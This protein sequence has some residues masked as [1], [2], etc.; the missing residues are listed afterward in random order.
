MSFD[1]FPPFISSQLQYLLAHYPQLIKVEQVWSGS[2]YF[3]GSLDR[4]TLLIPYCLDYLKWDIIYN[5][6]FPLAA[7]DVIFGPEDEDFHPFHVLGGE[8]KDLTLVKNSLTDWNNKDPTRLLAL[9]EELRDK[10]MSYQKKR[11]GEVDDDRLKF[12]ISTI[13][14]REGIEM[15]M[16][17]GVEK[18]EEVKFAVPLMDMNINKMVLACPWR[19]PQRIYLQVVYPVGRMYVSAPSAPRL[20]LMSSAELKALFS[21]DDVKLPPWLDGMCL[22]EYLPHLEQL[23]QR[24]VSEAVSLIDVRRRFIEALVLLF[25]RPLEADPVFCRKATFLATS[26]PFTLLVHFFLSTQF[27][28]QQPSMMLQSTQHFNS[29]GAPAKSPLLTEYPW[30]PRWEASQMAERIFDFLVDESVNFKRH[31][32]ESQLQH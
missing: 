4:F 5:V 16:S 7:P 10:Y 9:I 1:G 19:H 8:G 6:E 24:Q 2:K 28:K 13:L 12:E 27:P 22:A 20:K 14:S 25:G 15:H 17:S 29:H 11:V 21:I 30:S 3:P 18:P 23:L 26:G 31:C 32:N